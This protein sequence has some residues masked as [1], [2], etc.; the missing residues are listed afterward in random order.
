MMLAA[1]T[2]HAW[3]LQF[4]GT[5]TPNLKL[6]LQERGLGLT[7]FESAMQDEYHIMH[8]SINLEMVYTYEGTHDV[9]ALILG[10]AITGH[11]AFVSV[12]AVSSVEQASVEPPSQPQ[13]QA[14]QVS[15]QS[16]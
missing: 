15:L 7:E 9:H 6:N 12:A 10:K 4:P 11:N 13:A 1:R 5:K 3:Q 16:G 8:H 2:Q 14:M